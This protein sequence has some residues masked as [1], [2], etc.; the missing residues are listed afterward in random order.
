M[1]TRITIDFRRLQ[2]FSLLVWRVCDIDRGKKIRMGVRE[3]WYVSR[4][5][6]FD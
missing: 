5:V 2:L 3:A 1:K 6:Y 4:I